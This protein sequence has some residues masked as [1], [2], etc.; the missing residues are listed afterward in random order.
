MSNEVTLSRA[1][2]LCWSKKWMILILTLVFG[3]FAILY[4]I[5][6]ESLY[7]GKVHIFTGSEDT[8][9]SFLQLNAL[10]QSRDFHDKIAQKKNTNAIELNFDKNA[11]LLTLTLLNP[12]AGDAANDANY[13]TR[14]LL[15]EL[16]NK[17][18][19]IIKQKINLL[20]EKILESQ[21]SL[22]RLVETRVKMKTDDKTSD[23]YL[24]SE[25]VENEI[26]FQK[27]LISMLIKERA[28]LILQSEYPSSISIIDTAIVPQAPDTPNRK[29][30]IAIGFI[31]GFWL[32][33]VIAIA[34]GLQE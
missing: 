20:D 22:K 5:V 11:R 14:M 32:G 28:G 27:D 1:L 4:S 24:K 29:L 19:T 16:N 34:R 18:A 7:K 2:G 12:D 23:A 8:V 15:D 31:F 9:E 30:I 6:Q 3:I 13:I 33:V 25:L 26:G 10:L 17:K 21:A